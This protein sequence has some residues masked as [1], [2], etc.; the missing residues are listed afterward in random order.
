MSRP[1]TRW[2]TSTRL[3]LSNAGVIVCCFLVLLTLVMWLSSRFMREHMEE[4]VSAE[5]A[6]LQGD[7]QIDGLSGLVR[8]IEE[9]NLHGESGHLR[10]YRLEDAGR[11]LL[12]GNLA[13]WPES[14]PAAGVQ[15]TLPSPGHP[16][17]TVLLAQWNALPGGERLLVGF[18]EYELRHIE[19]RLR[20]AGTVS[21]LVVLLLAWFAGRYITH[22]VLRPIETIRQSARQIMEG[23]LRHRIP[24]KQGGDEFDQLS[25][26]LNGMLD[27]IAELIAGIE[28]ATD[29][30]AHD[31]RSPL[32]RHRARLEAALDSP[33][34]PGE[35]EEWVERNLADIDRVLS[36]FQA[37]LKIA[38]VDS[39]LLRSAFSDIDMA[40]LCRDAVEFMEPLAELR[41]QRL[42]LDVPERLEV[43]GHRDLLFQLLTNLLDNAI[44]YGPAQ[45]PVLLRCQ[46]SA[47][48][49]VLVVEDRGDGIPA[50]LHE[51]VFDR[52]YRL[53]AARQEAGQGLGLSLVQAV[54]RLHH[55]R[56]S[57]ASAEPGLRV[58]VHFPRNPRLIENT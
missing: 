41:E 32:T 44:K 11:H 6:M 34:P 28:G 35:W 21:L 51:R 16:G 36:T 23:D 19:R 25:A 37:L 52:L 9:R 22:T 12:A 48:T 17:R 42:L 14:A 31:L 58:S 50:A 45:S 26:T 20:Q 30:I 4:S 2:S 56:V 5:L 10:Y 3:T 55:G 27:R 43:R 7:Y 47:D 13:A 57:L 53:D 29:N 8:L 40:A 54:V 24:V 46:A 39:G 33:P 38:R 1:D 15:F 49:C 18:D